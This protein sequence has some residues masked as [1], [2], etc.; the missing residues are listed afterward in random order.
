MK[1]ASD[2]SSEMT[3][4]RFCGVLWEELLFRRREGLDDSYLK[5]KYEN[6]L[7][8]AAGAPI[9]LQVAAWAT[10]LAPLLAEIRRRPR[11]VLL[12][13]GCGCGSEALLA[14]YLGAEVTGVDLVQVRAAYAA[15]R[16]PFHQGRGPR[17]LA[18]SFTC[19]NVVKYLGQRRGF[20][21]IWC[22]EAISHIHPAE[23]FLAAAHAALEPGG[24]LII[25]DANAANPIAV[26]RAAR[27]RRSGS[28]YT[29]RQFPLLDDTQHDEAADERIFSAR[30]MKRML[31]KSG[32]AVRAVHMQGFLGSFFLPRRWQAS[33]GISR[34][35]CGLQTLLQHTPGLRA[36]GSCMTV[37]AEKAGHE[38]P[39][40]Q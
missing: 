2:P 28:W 40:D 29:L 3:A 38:D 12:D 7:F 27:I 13:A 14:A 19:A 37:V 24:R 33:A 20:D 26:L 1:T 39:A 22:N 23:E 16:L 4:E 6:S 5:L 18:V 32:F 35:M 8:T 11:P 17:E 9:H 21:L 34:A 15:S 25:A 10:R 36:L 30:A 31:Q